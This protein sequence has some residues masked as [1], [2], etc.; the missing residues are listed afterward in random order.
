M[1]TLSTLP[2][3]SSGGQRETL[4]RLR[5]QHLSAPT[6]RPGDGGRRP[7][8]GPHRPAHA[9]ELDPPQAVEGALD[10]A[11]AAKAEALLRA[12]L[13]GMRL[14]ALQRRAVAEG[15]QMVDADEV[16]ESGDPT[17]ASLVALVLR[18]AA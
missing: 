6:A 2:G 1:A 4:S 5:R 9:A 11:A 10:R 15:V 18:H 16:D 12:E 8:G 3:S 7:E 17:K 14:M 13:A